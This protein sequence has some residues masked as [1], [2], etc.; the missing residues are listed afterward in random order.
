MKFP[1]PWLLVAALAVAWLPARAQETGASAWST[2]NQASVRLIAAATAV[3]QADS[4]QLGLQ[5]QIKSGWKIYWRSPGDAG[6]A[7]SVDWSGSDNLADAQFSWP[8]P[9][10]FSYSGLETVGYEG[11]VVLPIAARLA[12]PGQPLSVHGK[13]DYL[14]CSEICVPRHADLDV[15]LPAGTAEPSASAH[16]ISRFLARVPGPGA[17]QGLTLESAVASGADTLRVV[18]TANPPLASPDLFVERAD[19]MQFG[20]PE[21]RVENG[22]TRIVFT[23]ISEPQTGH[24]GV[25]DAPVTLTVVDGDRGMEV[26]TRAAAGADGA[27]PGLLA[28][29]GIALLGGL[30]LNLMPCVLPVL[31]LKLLAMVGHGGAAARLIRLNFI[32]SGTG[33]VASFLVLG[34]VAIAAR[35]AGLAVGWG[36]QFQQPLFLATMIALVTLFAANLFGFYEIPVPIWAVPKSV[37][38]GDARSHA[39]HFLQGAFAALL[40]TPCSAPFLGTAVGFALARGPG[41]I[42]AIFAALGLGMSIPY[43]AVALWPRLV[44]HLPRPGRWMVILRALLG[45]ALVGTGVWLLFVLMAEAGVPAAGIVAVTMAAALLV[46]GAGRRLGASLRLAAVVALMVASAGGVIVATVVPSSASTA[47]A[48]GS[49]A[50]RGFDRAAIDRAV[51]DGKLAFVD[52]TADWCLTCKVNENAILE[53]GPVAKRLAASDV[54]AMRADWTRPDPAISNYLAAFGRYGIPFYAVYGP[55]APNGIALP[56]LLTDGAVLDALAKAA[57]PKG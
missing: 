38:H 48:A 27:E 12:K 14:I 6:I 13:L 51:A 8:A 55:G 53:R 36:V 2:N 45:L 3:G 9:H 11:E 50:W 54:V 31:S 57:K 47:G 22:G 29:I 17:L 35:S 10:R 33:I 1:S 43:T 21:V 44:R 41:E 24:G 7:P 23:V 26:T 40:A 19:Q 30:I 4:V 34:A 56:V 15:T 28:M 32:A 25:A 20:K 52:V 39:A 16:L 5:F 49:G 46:L 42:L 18:V 37:A